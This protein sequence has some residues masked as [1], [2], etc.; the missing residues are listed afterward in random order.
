M[1]PNEPVEETVEEL[2]D[3]V[4]FTTGVRDASDSS[5]V[6]YELVMT[7]RLGDWWRFEFQCKSDGWELI[8]CTARSDNETQ[9]HDLLDEVYGGYFG[10]FLMHVLDAAK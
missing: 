3:D 8:G 4:T 9:P 6:V 7:N 5:G 10:P 1:P 2:I